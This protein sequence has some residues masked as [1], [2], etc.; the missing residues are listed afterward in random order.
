MTGRDL[1]EK[2]NYTGMEKAIRRLAMKE[3]LAPVEQIALMSEV[4]VCDLIVE[5]YEVVYA[6]SEELGLV[7]KDRIKEYNSLVETICR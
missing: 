1:S 3:K 2:L 7:K 6:E 5:K 4:E